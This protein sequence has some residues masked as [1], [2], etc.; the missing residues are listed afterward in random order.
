MDMSQTRIL[1]Y[2]TIL[3]SSIPW[4]PSPWAT[5][6]TLNGNVLLIILQSSE[7]NLPVSSR[8]GS[9]FSSFSSSLPRA[10]DKYRSL[11]RAYQK[12]EAD[13]LVLKG[14]LNILQ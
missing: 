11:L 5:Y 14:Q 6:S 2:Q 3:A 4:T 1:V 12:L 8:S 13:N 7:M 10:P 9:T